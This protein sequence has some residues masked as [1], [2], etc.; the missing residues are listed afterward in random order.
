MTSQ[1]K[2]YV[3]QTY[4]LHG[5]D[6][7]QADS[8]R[9]GDAP[10]CEAC[11]KPPGF[12]TLVPPIEVEFEVCAKGYCDLVYLRH[13]DFLVSERFREIYERHGLTGLRGFDPVK[14]VKLKRRRRIT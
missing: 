5:C 4:R 12:L 6:A 3:L 10:T 8:Q 9:S 1:I 2:F 14:I 7:P 13:N 11:G